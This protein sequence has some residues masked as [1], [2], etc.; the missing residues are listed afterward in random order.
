MKSL[1]FYFIDL[2]LLKARPQDLPASPVVLWLILPLNVLVGV[3]LV[4]NTFG[5]LDKAMLAAMLDMVLLLL[6]V[7]LL[8]AFKRHPGRFTQSA[9]ALLGS[10]TLVGVLLIP[11]QLLVGDGSDVGPLAAMAGTLLFLLMIWLLVMVTYIFRHTLEVG[12]ALAF[13]LALTY[14]VVTNVIIRSLFPEAGAQ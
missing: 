5:G 6:W 13:G 7:W 10:T 12:I 1:L 11:L 4:G 9:T 8:L 2:C 14:F 3:A